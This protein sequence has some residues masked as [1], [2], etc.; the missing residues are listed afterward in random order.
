MARSLGDIRNRRK[1]IRELLGVL[2]AVRVV[3]RK[4]S[5]GVPIVLAL[6]IIIPATPAVVVRQV[7]DYIF[8]GHRLRAPWPTVA[9]GFSGVGKVVQQHEPLRQGMQAG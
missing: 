8:I 7:L 6:E 4:T 5:C 1:A 2:V 9:A 3:G